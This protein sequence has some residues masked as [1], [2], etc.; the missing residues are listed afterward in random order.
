MGEE[1]SFREIAEIILKGKWIIIGFITAAL[2]ISGIISFY[3]LE[4][5]YEAKAVIA[6]EQINILPYNIGGFG[7]LVNPI[8]SSNEQNLHVIVSRAKSTDILNNVMKRLKIDR[9]L[10]LN[11]ISNKIAV[12]SVDNNL[13]EIIIKDNT[14]KRAADIADTLAKELMLS[15]HEDYKKDSLIKMGLL[16][17]RV[18]EEHKRINNL[19]AELKDFLSQPESV[20]KLDAELENAFELVAA[21]QMRKVNLQVESEKTISAINTI[22]NQLRDMEIKIELEEQGLKSEVLNPVYIE[23]KKELELSKVSL[24]QLQTEEAIIQSEEAK[25]SANINKLQVKLAKKRIELEQ[26]QFNLN[27]VRENYTLVNNKLTSKQ[28]NETNQGTLGPLKL[29][30][31]ADA[32]QGP[33]GPKKILNLAIAACLGLIFGLIIIFV[34][35]YW[36]NSKPLN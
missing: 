24:A 2:L 4:P 12:Q 15:F 33:I 19:E 31:I 25:T 32:N 7:G 35:A 26:L 3:L 28:Y 20:A 5:V 10:T 16:E 22:E 11:D 18:A 13:I 8:V 36:V 9:K 23:L 29:V 27:A 30:S 17:S 1:I 14:A 21:L 34:R 6:V